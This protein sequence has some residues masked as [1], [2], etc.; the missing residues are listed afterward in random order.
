M[1]K[2]SHRSQMNTLGSKLPGILAG[3]TKLS[4]QAMKDGRLK[5]IVV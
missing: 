5:T 2:G 3:L 4:I 1:D